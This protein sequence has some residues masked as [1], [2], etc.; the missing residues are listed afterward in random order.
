MYL[1][2]ANINF[3]STLRYIVSS[4]TQI[5]KRH[6]VQKVCPFNCST[7]SLWKHWNVSC[8][9]SLL[10]FETLKEIRKKV[11]TELLWNILCGSQ[12]V[13]NPLRHP[14]TH[15]R[16]MWR[17]ETKTG[18]ASA[19]PFPFMHISWSFTA[20]NDLINELIACRNKQSIL[21]VMDNTIPT[22]TDC[23]TLH[24]TVV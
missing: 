14:D 16:D 15:C 17:P 1:L 20:C 24:V 19:L 5:L 6:I 2:R 21:T 7:D 10:R 8:G 22:W 9:P 4:I 13:F 11:L 23:T 18:K 3:S 12:H